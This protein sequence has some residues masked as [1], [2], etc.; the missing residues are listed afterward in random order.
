MPAYDSYLINQ[1][2]AA[3]DYNND[4]IQMALLSDGY[5]FSAA[6]TKR[7]SISAYEIGTAQTLTTKT[8]TSKQAKSDNV[9]FGVIANGS[10]TIRGYALFRNNGGAASNDDLVFYK[11]FAT[12]TPTNGSTVTVN[13]PAT[14]WFV[15]SSPS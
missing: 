10:G 11:Q 8:I 12:D 14:G 9:A 5:T 6:H 2:D 1:L 4:T 15:M 3:I 13:C 7:S